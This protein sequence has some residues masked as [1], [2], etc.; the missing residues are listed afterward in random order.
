MHKMQKQDCTLE[1]YMIPV[2][3]VTPIKLVKNKNVK[4]KNQNKTQQQRK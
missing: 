1:P 4:R 2:A 3:N